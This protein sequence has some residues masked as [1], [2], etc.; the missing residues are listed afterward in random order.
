MHQSR[1][2]SKNLP[3]RSVLDR[4]FLIYY[5]FISIYLELYLSLTRIPS[6]HYMHPSASVQDHGEGSSPG[7]ESS[8]S[9]SVVASLPPAADKA[10]VKAKVT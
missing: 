7:G 8:S 3:L 4:D 1:H 6:T 5:C 10:V 9:E 2:Y